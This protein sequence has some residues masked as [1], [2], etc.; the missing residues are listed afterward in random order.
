MQNYKFYVNGE[1]ML[2]LVYERNLFERHNIFVSLFLYLCS[3]YDQ[4]FGNGNRLQPAEH[5]E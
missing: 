4:S 2:K 5:A 1:S 3:H